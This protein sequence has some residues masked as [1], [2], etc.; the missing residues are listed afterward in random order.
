MSMPG[1]R[2]SVFFKIFDVFALWRTFTNNGS[3]ICKPMKLCKYGSKVDMPVRIVPDLSM[4]VLGTVFKPK[5]PVSI[6]V[7]VCLARA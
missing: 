4:R 6:G 2:R 7:C 3:A 1:Y 5:K